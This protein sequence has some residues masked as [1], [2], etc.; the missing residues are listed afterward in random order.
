MSEQRPGAQ[1]TKVSVKD[2]GSGFF[3]LVD[4][5]KVEGELFVPM[6]W[7]GEAVGIAE[8]V[9]VPLEPKAQQGG[10]EVVAK[11]GCKPLTKGFV[12]QS[13]SYC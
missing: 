7:L 13:C 3:E 5:A 4:G 10:V 6:V 11:D 9:G 1:L 12:G 8:V 2:L